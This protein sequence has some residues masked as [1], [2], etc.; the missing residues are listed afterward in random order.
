MVS[1]FKSDDPD[2]MR[3]A[4]MSGDVFLAIPIDIGVDLIPV[5]SGGMRFFFRIAP[6]FHKSGT[7]VP[8]G[9]IWQAYN[10]KIR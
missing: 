6:E 3:Q 10:L 7:V 1:F 2:D 4:D 8:I 5:D 9:F